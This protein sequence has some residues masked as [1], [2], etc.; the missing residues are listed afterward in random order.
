MGPS[1]A[2]LAPAALAPAAHALTAA[3]LA[4]QVP[5]VTSG[6]AKADLSS[7]LTSLSN[8]GEKILRIKTR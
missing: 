1:P 4:A 3:P 2:A 6:E 8:V 5:D 7:R